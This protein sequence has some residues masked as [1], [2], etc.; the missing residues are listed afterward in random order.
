MTSEPNLFYEFGDIV[1]VRFPFTNQAAS[2]Q[3]PA[4]V[5]S[6]DEYNDAG[7]DLVLM[8][9]TSQLHATPRFGN[10]PIAE[11]QLAGLLRPSAVKPI[12]ATFEQGLIVRR[13]GTLHQTDVAALR[14]AIATIIG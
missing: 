13:F 6:R 3:R 12:F 1:L 10:V 2:K 5:I 4:V 9:I 14:E 7:P 8:A 11:W